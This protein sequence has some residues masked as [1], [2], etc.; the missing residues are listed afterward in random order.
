[1]KPITYVKAC[2]MSYLFHLSLLLS[3]TILFP[4]SY[5]IADDYSLLEET[6]SSQE[7]IRKRLNYTTNEFENIPFEEMFQEPSLPENQEALFLVEL[8]AP[9]PALVFSGGIRTPATIE[10]ATQQY[11][12]LIAERPSQLEQLGQHISDFDQKV[13]ANYHI[14]LNGFAFWGTKQ[15]ADLLLEQPSVRNTTLLSRVELFLSETVPLV[16]APPMWE[17]QPFGLDGTGIRIGVIDSGIDYTHPDFHGGCDAIG[18][19]C[20]I[21][22]GYDFVDNDP[23]P[24]DTFGHG[25]SVAASIGSNNPTYSGIAPGSTLYAYRVLDPISDNA[26]FEQSQAR[27]IQA[28][29]HALVP[30]GAPPFTD[31]L[32]IVNLSLGTEN[33]R[34][35]PNAVLSIVA[36]RLVDS[37]VVVI[38]ASGNNFYGASHYYKLPAPASSRK[39]IT[40][41]SSDKNDARSF[42]SVSGPL[43]TGE[44]KPDVLAPG[45]FE[46]P[47]GSMTVYQASS[48]CSAGTGYY[49]ENVESLPFVFSCAEDGMHMAANGTS[50]SAPQV[51]GMVAIL[52]QQYPELSPLELKYAIRRNAIDLSSTDTREIPTNMI[53]QGFGRANLFPGD[54][55]RPHLAILKKSVDE[56]QEVRFEVTIGQHSDTP[57]ES[58]HYRLSYGRMGFA[59]SRYGNDIDDPVRW[60]ILDEGS[61]ATHELEF[62]TFESTS[63]SKP[64]LWDGLFVAKLELLAEDEETV[65]AQDAITFSV[66]NLKIASPVGCDFA[67]N[68]LEFVGRVI[69][70]ENTYYRIQYKQE[71]EQ[72]WNEEGIT[73]ENDGTQSVE[74]GLL[75][76]LNTPEGFETDFYAFQVAIF[77][78][79]GSPTPIAGREIGILRVDPSMSWDSPTQFTRQ[80]IEDESGNQYDIPTRY[81]ILHAT[82]HLSAQAQRELQFLDLDQDGE[83]KITRINRLRADGSTN[84]SIPISSTTHGNIY[85]LQTGDLFEE[86]IGMT[87]RESFS[88]YPADGSEYM[89][90][91]VSNDYS[92]IFSVSPP[93]SVPTKS[94]FSIQTDLNHDGEKELFFII[95]SSTPTPPYPRENHALLYLTDAHLNPLPGWPVAVESLDDPRYMPLPVVGNFDQDPELEIAFSRSARGEE[96]I[97]VYEQLE[98]L[99]IDGTPL[100]EHW[101]LLM[102]EISIL[103]NPHLSAAD[104]N[105]DGIDELVISAQTY[106]SVLDTVTR[107]AYSED[108]GAGWPQILPGYLGSD[109]TAAIGDINGDGAL[110]IVASRATNAPDSSITTFQSNGNQLWSH[111][112]AGFREV[113]GAKLADISGDGVEDVL[114]SDNEVIQREF[115][116]FR[117][118]GPVC[119]FS[120]VNA[121][122]GT[123]AQ[124]L[125][126]YPKYIE[127]SPRV[128]IAVL[129]LDEDGEYELYATSGGTHRNVRRFPIEFGG[130]PML[131][132]L[133]RSNVYRWEVEPGSSSPGSWSATQSNFERTARYGGWSP[134]SNVQ[135]IVKS[136]IQNTVNTFGIKWDPPANNNSGDG[137]II[138]ATH[139]FYHHY[140]R[141]IFLGA[142]QTS[143]R[144]TIDRPGIYTL[145][146]GSYRGRGDDISYRWGYE[147]QVVL[148]TQSPLPPSHS[149]G[150]HQVRPPAEEVPLLTK[151]G[152]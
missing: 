145:R 146:V 99:N 124:E 137:Y 133:A 114:F 93:D 28:M 87:F 143:G 138:Q 89:K 40:V 78:N 95:R 15:E 96:G 109:T 81:A 70:P 41:G 27:I 19:N 51:A 42:F 117:N 33:T 49:L 121:L 35:D 140:D 90:A 30:N 152:G 92:S 127:E 24:F 119:Y 148:S 86:P 139:M 107:E 29:E 94:G 72:E 56:D 122:D 32:D 6:P 150:W 115:K 58:L 68:H 4:S 76:T 129:D 83:N 53:S 7:L 79:N 80:H 67:S 62:R 18:P 13:I 39:A 9:A 120:R 97:T 20:Q 38:A 85:S 126:G 77:E 75:G 110:E 101:P 2:L 22:G 98:I 108:D 57:A 71:H 142:D 12:T 46:E 144:L 11:N 141:E 84:W 16:G 34:S 113:L 105:N 106:L 23:D 100:N 31:P 21:Q 111:P 52:K 149:G 125:E 134:P 118:P 82:Q 66:H 17:L 136:D 3:S 130:N 36:D 45:G 132:T 60:T 91:S 59:T 103:S 151:D 131:D 104:F 88:L 73:L 54:Q 10:L 25:T 64:L 44:I 5:G 43:L 102:E 55:Q 26:T 1:M 37:G 61:I 147:R 47:D 8:Q 69:L 14:L 50:L 116:D 65:L 135:A 63:I 123:T 48:V 74:G 112:L 128:D